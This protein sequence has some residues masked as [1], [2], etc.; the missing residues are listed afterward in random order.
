ML[1]AGESDA[2]DAGVRRRTPR[3]TS[4]SEFDC[5]ESE[6]SFERTPHVKSLHLKPRAFDFMSLYLTRQADAW[7]NDIEVCQSPLRSHVRW[8]AVADA[9][10]AVTDAGGA[11]E[12]TP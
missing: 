12:V 11:P 1:S 8:N 4:S 9:V 2:G 10:T 3:T 6:M 7:H 5:I